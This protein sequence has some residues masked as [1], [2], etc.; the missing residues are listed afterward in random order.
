MVMV[1]MMMMMVMVMVMVIM[2]MMIVMDGDGVMVMVMAGRR[3]DIV[4]VQRCSWRIGT[5]AVCIMIHVSS[6]VC[7]ISYQTT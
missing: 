7:G 4:L 6:A 1:M 3:I 2:V 5:T